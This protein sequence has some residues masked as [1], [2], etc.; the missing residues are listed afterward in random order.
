MIKALRQLFQREQ[1][2]KD[3]SWLFN[4]ASLEEKQKFME[5][6]AHKANADQRALME[7]Y[8]RAQQK[9]T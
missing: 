6:I 1:E 9:T 7:K 3:F 4:G 2:K 5:D 8:E